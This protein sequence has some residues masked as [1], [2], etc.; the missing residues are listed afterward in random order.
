MPISLSE[1]CPAVAD[2]CS[3]A[4]SRCLRSSSSAAL[5]CL[6]SA[7]I[8]VKS[9]GQI[10]RVVEPVAYSALSRGGMSRP[11]VVA[12]KDQ[13][14]LRS[15]ESTYPISECSGRRSNHS[16]FSS[17]VYAAEPA[18]SPFITSTSGRASATLTSQALQSQGKSE[19]TTS[20]CTLG[21]WQ[22]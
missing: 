11:P 12:S 8:L 4:S 20:S 3:A 10:S 22:S 7:S 16:R 2:S 9:R 19:D 14:S 13:D 21:T 1:A 17:F 6:A 5:F 18:Q 15:M